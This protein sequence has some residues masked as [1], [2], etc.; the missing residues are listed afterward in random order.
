[1]CS[2]RAAS[3]RPAT[4]RPPEVLEGI[5]RERAS[6]CDRKRRWLCCCA[7]VHVHVAACVYVATAGR[8]VCCGWCMRWREVSRV[9]GLFLWRRRRRRGVDLRCVAMLRGVLGRV[10]SKRHRQANT[11]T[12]IHPGAIDSCQHTRDASNQTCRVLYAP[13]A[14]SPLHTRSGLGVERA[15]DDGTPRAREE[16]GRALRGGGAYCFSS[17]CFWSHSSVICCVQTLD[18]VRLPV[19]PPLVLNSSICDLIHENV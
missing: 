14:P 12:P 13:G 2:S 5:E 6:A 15:R 10:H 16:A 17:L 18:D 11:H 4:P 7:R 8:A 1:M 19:S 3:G 9:S